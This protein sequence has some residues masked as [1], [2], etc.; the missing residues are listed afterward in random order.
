MSE[1]LKSI[2]FK[3]LLIDFFTFFVLVYLTALLFAKASNST[4]LEKTALTG[5]LTGIL[6]HI[7]V[8]LVF[9]VLTFRTLYLAY[10]PWGK[11]W[12]YSS[13][14]IVM[15]VFETIVLFIIWVKIKQLPKLGMI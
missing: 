8:T 15:L 12:A 10:E 14:F 3:W 1:F 5:Y 9:G 13:G 4:R 7:I 6:L 11:V 2:Y